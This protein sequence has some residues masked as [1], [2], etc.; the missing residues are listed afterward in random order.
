MDYMSY[1]NYVL[2][3]KNPSALLNS[4]LLQEYSEKT[5]QTFFK[6]FVTGA[7]WTYGGTSS[8]SGA[9]YEELRGYQQKNEKFDGVKTERI[10]FL[11]M[12]KV[13]TWVSLTI[14]FLLVI[15]LVVL[16]VAL[17]IVYYRTSVFRWVECLADVLAMIVGSDELVNWVNDVGVQGWTGLELTQGWDG[18]GIR[19]AS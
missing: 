6:H 4:T 7:N 16:V 9:A 1:A 11:N 17:Q 10:G 13:A 2:A 15:I 14:F 5:S 19:E 8:I 12:N 3:N 18:S